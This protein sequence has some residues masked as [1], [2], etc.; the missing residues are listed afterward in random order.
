MLGDRWDAKG[1]L[2][3]TLWQIPMV[4]PDMPGVAAKTFGFYDLI[5]GS[6]YVNGLFN[7]KTEQ[8]RMMPTHQDALFTPD[9]LAG[10]GVR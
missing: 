10:E 7:E 5:S 2:S 3:R 4:L 1:Q 8:N 6:W 9:A